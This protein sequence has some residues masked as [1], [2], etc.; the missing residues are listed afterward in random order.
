MNYAGLY[1]PRFVK[2]LAYMLQ[3]VEYDTRQFLRWFW[4]EQSIAGLNIKRLKPTPKSKLLLAAGWL[5]QLAL[6]VAA[7][8]LWLRW[9]GDRRMANFVLAAAV[10]ALAPAATAHILALVN[11]VG[12]WLIQKPLEV[13]R[14]SATR[15][16][17][18]NHRAKVIVIAGSYGKTS[19]KNLLAAVLGAKLKVAAAQGNYNTP[20]GIAKFAAAIKGDED[21]LIVEAG[22]Y[23][24]GDVAQICRLVGPDV[25][26]ITG[27]NEQHLVHMKSVENAIRTVFELAEALPK[28]AP[29]YINGESE[30]LNDHVAKGDIVYSRQGAGKFKISR[31][32]TGLSGT[33]LT[34]KPPKGKAFEL[35]T[36]LMGEHQA[37]PIAAAVHLAFSLGLEPADIKQGL[38]QLEATNRRFKPQTI[39]GAT[40]IDDSYNGNPDGFLAGIEFIKGLKKTGRKVYVTPGMI[41]LGSLSGPAHRA[42]GRKLAEA[43]VDL[44]VL[45]RNP[46]TAHIADGLDE[47]GFK[48]QLVWLEEEQNF[49]DHAADLTQKNDVVLLQNSPRERFFYL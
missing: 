16:I 12:R 7:A 44:V 49:L 23:R 41:E 47:A 42:V 10:T 48:G 34:I 32:S 11:W 36:V 9:W 2:A 38:E 3:S 30:Y 33:K 37:G 28:G 22:E 20:A 43:K 21:V 14:R 26:F 35:N 31:I 25:G 8:W 1:L 29:L 24:P 17:F 5:C 27:A 15:E 18:F 19:M 40:I 6:L 39:N 4:L 45:N 13:S 46:A